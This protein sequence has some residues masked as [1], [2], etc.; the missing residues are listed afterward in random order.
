MPLRIS[1]RF[2][3]VAAASAVLLALS[4][5]SL[6][7]IGHP[8]KPVATNVPHGF[9][10]FYGQTLRWQNCD[11][12][13]QCTTVKSPVNWDAPADGS[14]DLAVIRHRASG[15]PLGSLLVNPGGPGGSGVDFVSYG[16]TS[17]V[18]STLA[19]NYDVI[20]WDPRGVGQSTPVT[21][22][23]DPKQT[24]QELYGTFDQAY[25]TQ[26]WIDELVP[27]QKTFAAA[28]QKN[29]GELLAH[30]DTA[31]TARD[32]D[33]IRA[34][35]GDEKLNYLGYS[36]GTFLGAMYAELF[37]QNVGKM[38]LDG[39]LDPTVSS[40]D[41]LKVQMAGFDGAFRA[42]MASCLKSSDCPFTGSVDTALREARS[43]LDTVTAKHLTNPDGRVLD[44]ATLATGISFNLYSQ[45]YWPDMTS[46]FVALRSGDPSE[47]FDNADSYN[48]R[49]YDGSYSTNSFEVYTA[50]NCLDGDFDTDPTSTLDGVAQID[51]A[52][53]I[54]G[55]Y[56]AFDD[57][58]ML[59]TACTNWP[60]PHADLPTV[61]DAKGAPPI[62][63]IGT[64]NDP[65]TPLV[66]AQSLAKQLSSGVLITHK[67][68]GHTAYNRG[69]TCVD[70]AV[71]G[72]FVKGT[73]PASD[74]MC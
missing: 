11:S 28:C 18:S 50:V 67:G 62:L 41:E 3:A 47:V 7:P 63:V 6:L 48:S 65:A 68:E 40:L 20:G 60:V 72:Y 24:D 46:M 73:V 44:S 53:P 22:F 61:F 27:E 51:A 74:P 38:V 66:W 9:D 42:Y 31:S 12:G 70:G 21:C 37:P 5:C 39:A 56:M 25:G 57:Y 34:L 4:G 30:V 1:R 69:N 8:D 14:I 13:M 23:T 36:Y 10:E 29:T 35:L 49:S 55:K 45:Q 33:L 58:A 16:V 43:V 17:A 71:D 54:L 52:A 32:M 59:D 2:T 26:G 64:T 15:K 19:R